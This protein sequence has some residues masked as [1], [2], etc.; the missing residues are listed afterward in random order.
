MGWPGEKNGL[1]EKNGEERVLIYV[2]EHPLV[3]ESEMVDGAMAFLCFRLETMCS[4]F[5]LT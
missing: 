2:M 1:G 5:W 4:M 3:A